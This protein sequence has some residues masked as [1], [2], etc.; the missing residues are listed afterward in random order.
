[1]YIYVQ[2]FMMCMW[3]EHCLHG[4]VANTVNNAHQHVQN[5]IKAFAEM[6]AAWLPNA[7]KY[8]VSAVRGG[9][10]QLRKRAKDSDGDSCRE[11]CAVT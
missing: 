1:M 11:R 2:S 10:V 3:R 5:N 6:H 4:I 9:G 8:D 7:S